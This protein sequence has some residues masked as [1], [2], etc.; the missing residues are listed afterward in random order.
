MGVWIEIT[1]NGVVFKNGVSLPSWECGLK[2][3]IAK[4]VLSVDDVT[5]FVGVWIEIII[6]AGSSAH[7][8]VTPFV[9]VWI[10]IPFL[11]GT[12]IHVKSL[13]SWECGL[14]LSYP[15][16]WRQYFSSLPSWEC[17]LKLCKWGFWWYSTAV[18]AF[19]GVWIEMT[20]KRQTF[21]FT[22][23]TPFVGVWIEIHAV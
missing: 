11:S 1:D 7:R 9:G 22:K 3:N 6:G 8:S 10:E 12:S 23:V 18:T 14:K 17:G 15:L 13:P 21:V 5:P 4:T 20:T 19:V 16:C 2:S